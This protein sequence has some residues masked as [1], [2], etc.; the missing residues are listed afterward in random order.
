MEKIVRALSHLEIGSHSSP[1]LTIYLWDGS[2]GKLPPLNWAL[3]HQNGYYGYS[4][5]PFYF[6]YFDAA[7]TLSALNLETHRAHY[8]I[9]NIDELPWWISASPLQIILHV[10]LRAHGMQLTHVAAVGNEREALLL[11]GKG[12]SGKSATMLS[13]L[14]RGLFYLGEDYCILTN[15]EIPRVFSIYQS[16]KWTSHTRRLFPQY[17]ASIANPESADHEKALVYYQEIFPKQLLRELPIRAILSLK[18]GVEKP[19]RLQRHDRQSS[20]K[21]LLMSTLRQLPFYNTHTMTIVQGLVSR[22][23]H[24]HLML[25]SDLE[26]NGHMIEALLQ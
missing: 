19:P 2:L 11:A 8:V 16:A 15:E 1:D 22:V 12:G 9:R 20:L 14:R 5:P 10:W 21:N 24:Y 6:H 3:I 7:G 13:C 26:A 18:I 25:G 17:E 23:E 4:E